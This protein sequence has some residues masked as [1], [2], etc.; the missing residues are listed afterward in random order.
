MK[1]HQPSNIAFVVGNG[2]SRLF[3]NYDALLDLGSVYGCNAQ[4]RTHT[5][6]FLISVDV[7]MVNEIID[8]KYH[9]SNVV[10]TNPNHGVKDKNNINFFKPHKGWSSG[11]TALW[12]AATSGHTEIYILGF[13][14]EGNNGKLNNVYADTP[15]YKKSTDRAIFYGNWL[16]QTEK[17]IKEF[18]STRFIR[19]ISHDG[20]VPTEFNQTLKNLK[21]IDYKEFGKLFPTA[22]YSDQNDQKTTI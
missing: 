3:A 19:V 2:Q 1:P 9:L 13:D 21:H 8:S 10:W 5:P 12:L 7:K 11:P 18:R 4:Y 20:F 22:I 17:I 6:H 16:R 15:N 14:Y